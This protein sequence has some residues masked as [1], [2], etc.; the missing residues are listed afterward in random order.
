[1]ITYYVHI[2]CLLGE[3]VLRD[4]SNIVVAME[5]IAGT[6]IL[7]IFVIRM[8]ID[9]HHLHSKHKQN[10][11]MC[12]ANYQ[13]MIYDYAIG[14]YMKNHPFYCSYCPLFRQLFSKLLYMNIKILIDLVGKD[15]PEHFCT[16]T[17]NYAILVCFVQMC[18]ILVAQD[19]IF[20]LLSN[21]T[22]TLVITG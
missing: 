7:F 4:L 14:W 21:R 15:N 12:I 9:W 17:S 18:M 6:N 2:W 16:F 22:L 19:N 10:C 8:E 11:I 13:N 3:N 5:I 20:V 1:M